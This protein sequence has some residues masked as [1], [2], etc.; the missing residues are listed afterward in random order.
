MAKLTDA[1]KELIMEPLNP[2]AWTAQ[3]G[4]IATVREDGAPNIGPK[5]SCRIY[6]DSTLIWNENTAGEIMKD[7]ERGSKVAVAFANWDKLDGY[8]F[9]GT[10][11]VHKEGKYYY[12]VKAWAE[13][14]MG[15]PKAAVVFHIEEVYTLKSGPSAG[16]RVDQ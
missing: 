16:T 10:Y 15:V 7:I 5:R 13:G 14:K 9:V 1:I 3:L 2:K 11:E 6:D 4:W 12:E 8:R